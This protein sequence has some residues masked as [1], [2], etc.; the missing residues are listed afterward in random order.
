MAIR[1][2]WHI[3]T[4]CSCDGA[5]MEYEALIN[6]AKKYGITDLG[7]SDHYHTRLQEADIAASRAEYEKMIERHP[8]LKGHFH[9][10][11]EATL[12]SQWEVDKIARGEYIS[13]PVYGFRHGG[14]AYAPVILDFNE[15]F[16]EKYKIEYVVTGVHWP[17]YCPTDEQSLLKEYH[18]QYMYAA[19]HP[20]TDILA[21]YTWY[22]EYLNPGVAN[23]F[24]D[25]TKVSETMRSELKYA[26]IENKVAYEL[27]A[28][29][30]S[31]PQTFIDEYLG[32]AAELQ[33]SGVVL[34]QGCDCHMPDLSSVRYEETAKIYEHY[35]IKT[36]DFFRL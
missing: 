7:V 16:L 1:S 25:F 24:L 19:T 22:D 17:M 11:M 27:N 8:E 12:V 15:E 34:S 33:R 5:C 26:L 29:M 18:R 23:P 9:F 35:G 32:F 20:F 36:A 6:D 28:F 10:G 21:H 31:L 13:P 3:H 14:P 2:D 30:F 4:H